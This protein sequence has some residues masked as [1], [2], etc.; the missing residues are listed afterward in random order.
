[1]RLWDD[2]WLRMKNS[3]ETAKFADH[4]SY[5]YNGEKID[6]QYHLGID[7]ASLANSPIEAAN[8]G[9]VVFAEKN[10]IYGLMVVLDHGQ[11]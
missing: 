6:E 5:F 7:L 8:S 10:G 1:M 4:R 3:G 2:V 9:T 11:A